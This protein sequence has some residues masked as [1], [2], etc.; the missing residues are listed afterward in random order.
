MIV[1]NVEK[2]R[3]SQLGGRQVKRFRLK[4]IGLL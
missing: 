2:K 1:I 3:R 4:V